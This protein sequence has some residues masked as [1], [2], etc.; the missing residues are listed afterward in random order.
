[1]AP[2]AI[3]TPPVRFPPLPV[4][5]KTEPP[6]SVIVPPAIVPPSSRQAPI[7]GESASVVP[8]LFSVPVRFTT[9]PVA[10]KLPSAALVNDPPRLTV[11]PAAVIVPALTQLLP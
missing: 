3:V 7:A 11:A 5:A 1:M 6:V 10:L 9:A 4:R 2:A 8:A